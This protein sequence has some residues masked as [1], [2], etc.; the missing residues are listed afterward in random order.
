MTL[1][2]IT[3]PKIELPFDLSI[4]LHPPVVHFMIALPVI[5]LLLELLNLIFKKKAIGGINF[6]LI[7]LTMAVAAVAYLT[8]LTDGKEAYPALAEAGKT[9]LSEHKL[10]GTYLL[11]APAVVLVF[12]FLSAVTKN[13]FMKFLYLVVLMAFVYGI[14]VQGKEGGELVYEHGM[15][16]E[17]V[18]SLDDELFDL[19]EEVEELTEKLEEAASASTPIATPIV[20]V[21]EA[22][23]VETKPAVPAV[24]EVVET[25]PA[26][27]KTSEVK[28]IPEVPVVQQ[29]PAVEIP[30]A[31]VETLRTEMKEE[32]SVPRV[33]VI[34]VETAQ[35]E[36]ATH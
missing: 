32:V 11:L 4:L 14:F 34:P 13:G 2:A 29:T 16:V 15:N 35:P 27:V 3:L 7:F 21:V 22:P 8:G 20:P 26:A 9:A 10:L 1:P 36:I 24:K 18:A 19:K 28:V 6:F 30:S 33:E 31:P 5:I 17:K 25:A 12:K 23:K